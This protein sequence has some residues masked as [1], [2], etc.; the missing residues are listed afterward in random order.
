MKL[1]YKKINPDIPGCKLVYSTEGSSGMDLSSASLEDVIIKP[2][3]TQLIPTNLIIEIPKGCEG[4]VRPRSGL[5]WKYGIT[6]LNSPG[7]IDCDY[8]GEVKVLLINHG[9]KDFSVKF[10]ER[11]AQLIISTYEKVDIELEEYLSSTGRGSGG[12]G[13]TGI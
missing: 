13:S 7:T 9:K 1:L 12:Y 2:G 8:R 11:I 6:V 5:A 3:E 4:Q 10:G